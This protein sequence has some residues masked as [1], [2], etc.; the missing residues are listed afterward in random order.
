MA[1]LVPI[2][3]AFAVSWFRDPQR[4][5]RWVLVITGSTLICT[6]VAAF[7]RTSDPAAFTVDDLNA[8]LI[9]LVALL[10][11]LTTLA[12][13]RTKMRRFSL[14][15]SLLSESIRLATFACHSPWL[16]IALLAA[17]TL[18]SLVELR[19]R[20]RPTGA[21]LGQRC[22]GSGG[23]LGAVACRRLNAIDEAEARA[24]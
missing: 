23:R 16:L 15:W 10:H 13:A 17:G 9:V 18:T 7:T 21:A 2:V 12:T 3:G 8:P 20:G 22:G 14:S 1:I 11:F 24:F 4:A 19:N 6:I 5:A